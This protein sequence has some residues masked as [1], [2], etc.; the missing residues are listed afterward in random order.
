[1]KLAAIIN[2]MSRT[3]PADAAEALEAEIRSTGH[4]LVLMHCAT[5]D[6]LAN[7]KE[8]A[9]SDADAV[10]A[11]GG[12]GTAACALTACAACRLPVLALPGGT[13]NM[14]PH[15]LHGRNDDWRDILRRILADPVVDTIGAGVIGGQRFYVAALFGRLTAIAES[16]EA[17]RQGALLEA[18]QAVI[19]NQVLDVK[20]RLRIAS[21]HTSG[22]KLTSAVAAAIVVSA[23]EMPALEIATVDPESTFELLATA[24][25]AMVHGWRDAEP[26]ER[27]ISRSIM[28]HDLSDGQ[29]P[30]TLDGERVLFN[31]PVEVKLMDEAARILRAGA[32]G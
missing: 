13:M 28:I 7:V 9:G 23:E 21:R 4:D 12:D 24:V 22:E 3:V 25:D 30:A 15:R 31:S 10:I 17:V 6:L 8:A 1:M 32:G 20:T 2:P 26:V 5:D 29:I 19:G 27:H 18:A 11:W 14:L 16:R